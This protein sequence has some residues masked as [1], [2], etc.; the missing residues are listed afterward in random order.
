MTTPPRKTRH[1]QASLLPESA[2]RAGISS[3]NPNHWRGDEG[4]SPR[5]S[6]PLQQGKGHTY[7]RRRNAA[8]DAVGL[9]STNDSCNRTSTSDRPGG[10]PPKA[11]GSH[12]RLDPTR[13][14]PQCI[15][16][17]EKN[18]TPT[19]LTT[20]LATPRPATPT[21]LT[22]SSNLVRR[23]NDPRCTAPNAQDRR[24]VLRP[25]PP[26]VGRI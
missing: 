2:S 7:C 19:S 17:A 20:D 26:L 12:N 10:P 15:L 13:L 5:L 24:R 4:T 22:A 21:A 18:P 11:P 16:T 23:E 9:S 6:P 25:Q 14:Q 8:P 3:Q 1:P